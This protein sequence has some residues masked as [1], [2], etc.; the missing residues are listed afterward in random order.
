MYTQHTVF[1]MHVYDVYSLTRHKWNT[2]PFMALRGSVPQYA[3]KSVISRS[4][5]AILRLFADTDC[6]GN[7]LKDSDRRGAERTGLQF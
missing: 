5:S 4:P 7:P 1:S 3:H 2:V 6:R